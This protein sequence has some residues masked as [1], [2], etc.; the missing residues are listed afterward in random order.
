MELNDPINLNELLT[1]SIFFKIDQDQ[2]V[3]RNDEELLEDND[4]VNAEQKQT[5]SPW[6]QSFDELR[7]AMEP[8]PNQRDLHKQIIRAG[9][10]DTLG[11]ACTMYCRIHWTY[12]MFME[13][14]EYSFD[15]STT[16]RKTECDELLPGIWMA[17]RTMRKGEESQFVIGYR[18]MYGAIGNALGT[19]RIKPKADILLVAKLV[20]F[21]EIGA[22]D[23]CNQLTTDELHDYPTVKLRANEMQAKMFDCYEQRSFVNAIKIGLDIV[24]RVTFCDISTAADT[25]DRNEFLANIYVKLIDCYVKMERYKKALDMVGKLRKLANVERFVDVMV[26]EAIAL[27]K[28]ADNYEQPIELLRKA[29][30]LYPLNESVHK[31]LNDLQDEQR[32]Y[33]A[34]TKAFMMKAFQTKTQPSATAASKA[35]ATASASKSQENAKTSTS[36]APADDPKLTAIIQSFNEIDIGDGMPLVG[37]TR[38]ELNKV[39]EACKKTSNYQLKVKRSH[40]GQTTYMIVKVE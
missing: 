20:D 26:N 11:E 40:D 18:L 21:E 33:L 32:K 19:Y 4:L 8:I 37:Y 16:L 1:K 17:L 12:S 29:Q 25:Q 7:K 24:E 13:S 14:E 28:T 39:R 10:G 27:G 38:D 3:R 22:A 5:T 6:L 31:V 34:S 35:T 30:R 23:A 36:S 9:S 2:A 15:S